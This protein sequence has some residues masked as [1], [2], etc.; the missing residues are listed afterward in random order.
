MA[1]GTTGISAQTLNRPTAADNPNLSGNSVWTAACGSAGFNEYYVNFTW[2]P[3]VA[4]DNEFILELSDANG[5]FTTATE[6]SRVSD[7]NTDFDFEFNFALPEN[8]RGDAYR[9]RVR[10]T[11]PAKTSPPSL[12]FEMYYI[13]F[14]TTINIRELGDTAPTPAKQVKLC[15]GGSTTLEVYNV[16]NAETYRYNWYRNTSPYT[17]SGYGPSIEVTEGGFYVVE[18]DYGTTCSGSSNT[19][20]LSMEVQIGTSVGLALNPPVKTVLC[21]GETVAPLEANMN[22][23]DLFYTWFKDGNMVQGSTQGA[24]TYAI[25]TNDAQFSGDYT[26][27]I[28]GDGICTET[29]NPVTITQAGMFSVSRDNPANMVLLPGQTTTL[30]VTSDSTPVS[31]QW[32]KDNLALNGETARTLVANSVG[33]YY[34]EVSLSGGSCPMAT[35]S[36]ETT[37]LV[38]PNAFEF[39]IDYATDYT[40]CINTSIAMEISRINAVLSDGSKLDVTTDL[41]ASFAYQWTKDGVNVGGATSNNISLINTGEN[42]IYTLVG[43]L[44]GFNPVSNALPVRLLTNEMLAITS[45]ATIICGTGDT[46]TIST[47]TD[48]SGA[49]FRWSKDG[50]EILDTSEVLTVSE[51]GTYQLT[52]EKNGCDLKSNQL[53]ITPFDDSLIIL[54]PQTEDILF[55][56]GSSREVSVTGANSYQWFDENK[57]LLGDTDSVTLS[58]EGTYTII[59]TINDCQVSKTFTVSYQ[60][61]F[62]VPNVITANG[63]GFNDQWVLPNTYT[64][65][66][67]IHVIIYNQKGEE[68]LNQFQYKNNWPEATMKFPKQNMVFYY[69]IKNAKQTLKKGT[70]TVIR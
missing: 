17:V 15:G 38:Y 6:L 18:L 45:N 36:S 62:G 26:V 42:G 32:Y 70:I 47:S 52:V 30:S 13:D 2:L 5:M 39:T 22:Y 51:P 21:T 4:V 58:L 37:T 69:T 67:A 3:T 41:K 14:N 28:Q 23:P 34:A 59:A 61:T 55:P 31:Y 43:S 12:P 40:D 33:V 65:D 24:Y 20:S 29:S 48:L 46:A 60:D 63:D 27:R 56:E 19:Q 11:K 50:L 16:P 64:K 10:S 57:V 7:K 1:L 35:I 54:N 44:D 8:T 9:F 53:V 25:D 66:P 68:V 49:T